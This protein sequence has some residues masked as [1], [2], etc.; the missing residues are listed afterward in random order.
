[1]CPVLI[2]GQ[3]RDRLL[4]FTVQLLTPFFISGFAS[5]LFRH[6]FLCHG[7]PKSTKVFFS[8]LSLTPLPLLKRLLLLAS[9]FLELAILFGKLLGALGRLPLLRILKLHMPL[10]RLCVLNAL[11]VLKRER[12]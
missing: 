10:A 5:R 12:E 8:F 7:L 6:S 3:I 4:I 1:F 11:N 9:A 2:A